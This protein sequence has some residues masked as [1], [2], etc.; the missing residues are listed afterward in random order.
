[1]REVGWGSGQHVIRAKTSVLPMIRKIC[2]KCNF[3]SIVKPVVLLRGGGGGIHN[4]IEEAQ[5]DSQM[6][7][8]GSFA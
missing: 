3:I 1:M 6:W 5:L 7:V 8:S 2:S 4:L